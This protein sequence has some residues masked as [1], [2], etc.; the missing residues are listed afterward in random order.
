MSLIDDLADAVRDYPRESVDISIVDFALAAG[1]GSVL[2]V[3][4][5]FSFRIR[6]VNNGQLTMRDLRLKALATDYA[7]VRSDAP[8]SAFGDEATSANAYT[9]APGF[10]VTTGTFR[11]KATTSTD[12]SSIAVVK[13]LVSA[14]NA[15]LDDLL[16]DQ[17]TE[18][19]WY[20]A[21]HLTKEVVP[22]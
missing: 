14:W 22:A 16:A 11:G 7:E 1:D 17:S 8:S 4:D 6:A 3:G 10:M 18:G 20:T 21:A 13:A 12:G 9:L 15:S 5:T 2:N 19:A